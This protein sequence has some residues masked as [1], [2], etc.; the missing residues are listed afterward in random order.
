MKVRAG[1][2]VKLEETVKITVLKTES[3]WLVRLDQS[4]TIHL[5][6]PVFRKKFNCS[7]NEVNSDW[8]DQFLI[9]LMNSIKPV[10]KLTD[11]KF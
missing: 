9:E 7:L 3:S 11:L 10:K 4:R 5:L 6:G 8:T 2:M 1:D